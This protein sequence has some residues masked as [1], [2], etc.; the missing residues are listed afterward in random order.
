MRWVRRKP[1]RL[2]ARI[3]HSHY[4]FNEKKKK[5]IRNKYILYANYRNDAPRPKNFCNT[6]AS[7]DRE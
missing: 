2:L 4:V 1:D 3:V 5:R 7:R 6:M